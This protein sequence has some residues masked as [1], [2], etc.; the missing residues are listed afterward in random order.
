MEAKA[1]ECVYGTCTCMSVYICSHM[2][3]CDPEHFEYCWLADMFII[4][5][6]LSSVLTTLLWIMK[7]YK[8]EN[9]P[10]V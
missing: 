9:F 7:V 1:A 6:A 8:I 2:S 5:G 3:G 10:S 4:K